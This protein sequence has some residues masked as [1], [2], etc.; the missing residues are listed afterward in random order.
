MDKSPRDKI[1]I[2]M[3]ED[4]IELFKLFELFVCVYDGSN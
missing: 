2:M 4:I 3:K 1:L